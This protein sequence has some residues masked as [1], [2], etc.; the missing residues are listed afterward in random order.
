V[1]EGDLYITPKDKDQLNR[2]EA[3]LDKL[4]PEKEDKSKCTVSARLSTSC[5]QPSNH[6]RIGKMPRK[7]PKKKEV[8][9]YGSFGGAMSRG[10]YKPEEPQST[11]CV[12]GHGLQFHDVLDNYA[13]HSM[14]CE[15]K[16]YHQRV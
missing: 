7:Q 13:C 3:K 6:G 16:K 12:C 11:L 10:G 5:E 9:D 2:I 14:D 4:L 1:A 15:C 8:E